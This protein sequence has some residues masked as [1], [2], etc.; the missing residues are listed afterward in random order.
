MAHRTMALYRRR[1]MRGDRFED[2]TQAIRNLARDARFPAALVR[3]L[4]RL[5]GFRNVLIHEYTALDLERVVEG[6]HEL[7]P[8]EEF[9][10]IVA[11]IEHAGH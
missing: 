4:E 6:L 1:A 5:P 8:V 9:V 7:G 3:N 11:E 2:C 10:A